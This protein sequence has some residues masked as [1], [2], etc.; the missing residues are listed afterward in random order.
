VCSIYSRYLIIIPPLSFLLWYRYVTA[1]LLDILAQRFPRPI[2]N[3]YMKASEIY[4][5]SASTHMSTRSK[6]FIIVCIAFYRQ[7]ISPLPSSQTYISSL[8]DG[9]YSSRFICEVFYRSSRFPLP[10]IHRFLGIPRYLTTQ[11]QIIFLT[12]VTVLGLPG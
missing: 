1:L 9:M 2:Y 10:M 3:G 6:L 7:L 12:M 4:L 11:C 5:M 8:E